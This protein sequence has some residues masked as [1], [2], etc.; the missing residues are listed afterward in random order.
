MT[1]SIGIPFY[2]PGRAFEKAVRSVFSQ[3]HADWELILMDDGSSDGSLELA[4]S[5][6]DPRVRVLSDGA[7][8]GLCARL[9]QIAREARHGLL[10]RM[11]ADD[12]MHPDRLHRQVEELTAH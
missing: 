10:C 1:V 6:T 5:I 9:N 3:T 4:R 7:N 11:D 2:N 8:R 12:V